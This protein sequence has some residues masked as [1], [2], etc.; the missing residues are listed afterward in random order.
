MNNPKPVN[1]QSA[2]E[3]D[4]LAVIEKPQQ[5]T[6]DQGDDFDWSQL[7][8]EEVVTRRQD[9]IAIYRNKFGGIV[10]RQEA[11]FDEEDDIII[12]NPPYVTMLI[13]RLQALQ[14]EIAAGA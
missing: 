3:L 13:Q 10:L 8:P 14:R 12:V 9:E 4:L 6:F 5:S 1:T 2:Q 11:R 7:E